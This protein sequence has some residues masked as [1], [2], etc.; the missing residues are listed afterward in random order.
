MPSQPVGLYRGDITPEE[1][2][3]EEKGEEEEESLVV[4]ISK[5]SRSDE[6]LDRFESRIYCRLSAFLFFYF[7]FTG[8]NKNQT[9]SKS[10]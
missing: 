4:S 9:K 5:L 7:L 6:E 3:E 2:E 1:E 8:K 10:K